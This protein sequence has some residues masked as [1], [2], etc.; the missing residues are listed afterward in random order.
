MTDIDL[1]LEWARYHRQMGNWHNLLAT[2][3][4]G[5]WE[6]FSIVESDCLREISNS[7][8]SLSDAGCIDSELPE[9]P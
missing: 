8:Q 4:D 1:T 3:S 9:V 2:S 7:V 6:K 5:H